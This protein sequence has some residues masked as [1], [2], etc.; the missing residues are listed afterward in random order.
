MAGQRR[1]LWVN[2]VNLMTEDDRMEAFSK[3]LNAL[4]L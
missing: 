4:G 3:A 1:V 2:A